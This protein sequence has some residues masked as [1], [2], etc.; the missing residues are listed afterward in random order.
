MHT[1]TDAVVLCSELLPNRIVLRCELLAN[2]GMLLGELIT[3]LIVLVR[4]LFTYPCVLFRQQIHHLA[5]LRF[6]RR[7][8]LGVL[9]VDVGVD[10]IEIAIQGCID[11]LDILVG[12]LGPVVVSPSIFIFIFNKKTIG[13]FETDSSLSNIE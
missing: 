7:S 12:S 13:D 1:Y 2:A 6:E 3:N 5:M 11:S 4:Q 10:D 9:G 8:N